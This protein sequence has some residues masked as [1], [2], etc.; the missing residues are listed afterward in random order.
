MLNKTDLQYADEMK[1][2]HTKTERLKFPNFSG[3]GEFTVIHT[4]RDVLYKTNGFI[5]KN[6]DE[7]SQYLDNAIQT[8]NEKMLE[9]VKINEILA[10]KETGQATGKKNPK[11]KFLGY[12][13]R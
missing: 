9:I 3:K 5:E 11:E 1:K 13:F 4:A 12:K 7:V 8:C 6:K 2:L 10:A